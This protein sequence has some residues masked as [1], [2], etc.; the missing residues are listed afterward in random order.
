MF[1][2]CKV[3]GSQR[4]GFLAKTWGLAFV[5][6]FFL[7]FFWGGGGFMGAVGGE[8]LGLHMCFKL[9]ACRVK[10]GTLATV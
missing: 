5:V 4:L 6:F 10:V 2:L 8:R 1:L 9:L 3:H 7:V